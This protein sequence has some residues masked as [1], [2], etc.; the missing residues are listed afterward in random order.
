MHFTIIK[1]KV[2]KKILVMLALITV[3]FIGQVYAQGNITQVYLNATT[4]G[5][6]YTVPD[7]GIYLNS[8]NGGVGGHYVAGTDYSITVEGTCTG[9]NH[10]ALIFERFNIAPEDT[11]Y[12]Y[13]GPSTSSVLIMKSNNNYNPLASQTVY[14]SSLNTSNQ[15][16]I[17]LKANSSNGTGFTCLV[18]CRFPCE[19]VMPVIDSFY[20]KTINGQIVDTCYIRNFT[21][22]E[23]VATAIDSTLTGYDT[24]GAPIYSY[25]TTWT[26]Q[27]NYFRGVTLCVG[28]GVI[29]NGHGEYTQN[30]G[31]YTPS[32]M[33]S[34]FTWSLGNGEV[35]DEVGLRQV[36]AYYRDLDCYDV[37]LGIEDERGC[38]STLL[39]TV[40]VRLAQN[41]IKTLFD[42]QTMCNTDSL[43]VNVGY[44]G[45]NGTITLKKIEFEKTKT[46][47]NNVR[48]FVPDGKCPPD[49]SD[50]FTAKVNFD[51]FPAG[52]A[53]TDK[54]DICSIC[55]NA[56]HSFMGDCT[57]AIICPSGSKGYL[58]RKTQI[59]GEDPYT[60]GGSGKFLG[61]PY[62]GNNDGSWD[63][64]SEKCDSLANMYGYGW[65]YC[66]TRNPEYSIVTYQGA[67]S[68][69]AV[70]D[71]T[72]TVSH[73]F[74]VIPAPFY[75]AGETC[76]TVTSSNTQDSSDHDAKSGYYLPASDF[77]DLVGCPLNGEWGMEFCD[78]WGADNGWIFSFSL[79]ICGISSGAGCEYQVGLDSLVWRP[80]SAYGDFLLG[81]YRG[82]TVTR[83]DSVNAWIATPD[84]A[85]LFGIHVTLYDEFGCVWDTMTRITTVWAPMPELGDDTIFCDFQTM[86]LDASDAHTAMTNQSFKWEPFGDS[87][88]VIETRNNMGSDILYKVEVQNYQHDVTCITRDSIRVKVKPQ[89]RPSFDPGVYPLEGCEPFII[90]ITNNTPNADKHIWVWGDGDTSFTAEPS[91]AYAAGHYD[92][93]YYAESDAGC[94][95]S[96]V[97]TNLITVFSSPVAKFSW[98]PVNPTVMHPE[99]QFINKTEPQAD[100]NKYY[101]EIQY[102]RDNHLS[103][104]TMT[105]VNP[106]FQWQ[107]D[108]EDIS[109]TYIARL[110]AKTNNLGPSGNVVE[111]RDTIENSILLVNDFLQ[112]P[113]VVTPNGDGI[114][115]VFEIKNLVNGLG[116]PNNSLAIYNRWGKRVYFKENIS[117]D[118][119]WW[120]PAKDNI[121]DGTYFWR[122]SGKGYL[123]NIQRTGSVEVLSN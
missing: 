17:R 122:F 45:E 98:E 72:V 66:W 46:Q 38:K 81:H 13:D 96:L 112:F 109:G 82:A 40:R 73:T 91:H 68:G 57:Y 50:C 87:V 25:D 4:N 99:V 97:Y 19:T 51:D 54:G 75:R 22:T 118:D 7:E 62:G 94:K 48:T 63:N 56:E 93:K 60:G 119:D 102:D 36:A 27:D 44:E 95:D 83:R 79:D 3:G 24:N 115:D 14:A 53:V 61:I 120:D 90:N 41:P 15:L 64:S 39:E 43:L 70:P 1:I 42:L 113:T 67:Q 16:T 69:I 86:M 71:H 78:T 85:G 35:V 89:P 52:R 29:F 32:D 74:G 26:N 37:I 58:K 106:V 77:N 92:F 5:T 18:G 107:T 33:S 59:E 123:G 6:T 10:M 65:N 28:E 47:V 34:I 11:L 104:H 76:G 108:G 55:V 111:C 121:P 21:T 84:T 23:Q 8:D 88:A 110:I 9:L 101:W 116:Y 20:Y 31:A 12:I 30:Y 80:D 2:M 105:D 117:S 49:N 100:T 103:Y 114:N